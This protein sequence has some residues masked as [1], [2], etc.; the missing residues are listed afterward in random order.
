MKLTIRRA[1]PGDVA[2]IEELQFE[3]I[4]WLAEKGLDQW[5]PG[6]PRAPRDRPGSHL[7]DSLARGTCWIAVAGDREIA[8]ITIDD[9]ADPDFWSPDEGD[10]ALYAHRMIVRRILAGQNLGAVLLDWADHLAL[11]ANRPLLRLDAWRTNKA[12]HAYYLGQGF[13]HVR[14]V[15]LP[16]R[17]SGAL[18]ERQV[19]PPMTRADEGA[20][21][22]TLNPASPAGPGAG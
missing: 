20:T 14:T 9:I 22:V 16:N 17:G 1:T 13:S 15:T 6:Q 21:S 10:Q 19:R 3:S 5:Q 18:F 12:L 7:E 8:T 2:A 11:I 4:G